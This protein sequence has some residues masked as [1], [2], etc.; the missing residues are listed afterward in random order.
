MLRILPRLIDWYAVAVLVDLV[1]IFWWLPFLRTKYH[2]GEQSIYHLAYL[3]PTEH[4]TV[5]LL[6]KSGY[7][8]IV[9]PISYSLPV[10]TSPFS[11]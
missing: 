9:E 10:S 1:L 3:L 5:S 2:P 6:I 11:R 8:S 7:G 4:A